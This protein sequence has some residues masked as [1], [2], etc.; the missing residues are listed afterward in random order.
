ME[1][2][3]LESQLIVVLERPFLSLPESE[4]AAMLVHAKFL[5]EKAISIEDQESFSAKLLWSTSFNLMEKVEL[6]TASRN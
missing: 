6:E 3:K 5:A 2:T 4:L 1:S